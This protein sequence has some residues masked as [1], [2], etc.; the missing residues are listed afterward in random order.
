MYGPAVDNVFATNKWVYLYHAPVN[1]DPPYPAST[2]A[3]TRRRPPAGRSERV[4]RFGP[5][6][7]EAHAAGADA[8]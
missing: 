2:P 4:Q 6:G 8:G 7:H 5:D 3:G 1:M